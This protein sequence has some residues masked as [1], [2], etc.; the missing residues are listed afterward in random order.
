MLASLLPGL[1]TIRAPLAA[2]YVLL[3]AALLAFAPVYPSRSQATGVVADLYSLYDAAGKGPA[4][5][6]I[7]F[8][9]YLVGVVSVEVTWFAFAA[10]NGVAQLA[11]SLISIRY[12]NLLGGIGRWLF[13][14]TPSGSST[15]ARRSALETV[16]LRHLVQRYLRDAGFREEVLARVSRSQRLAAERGSHIPAPLRGRPTAEVAGDILERPQA[17]RHVIEWFVDLRQ[18]AEDLLWESRFAE[19]SAASVPGVL[20]ERDRRTAEADFRIGLALPT[21]ALVLVL[22]YRESVWFFLGG[23]VSVALLYMGAA[24]YADADEAVLRAVAQGRVTWPAAEYLST[25]RIH[26]RSVD[27]T[28]QL[29]RATPYGRRRRPV[30]DDADVAATVTSADPSGLPWASTSGEPPSP[31]RTSSTDPA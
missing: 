17:R 16:V 14:L 10:A 26:Y 23:L 2:G 18:H 11:Y 8:A 24:M 5:A 22:T 15:K 7:T 28:V 19:G 29:W 12:R 3:L 27:E 31:P 20:E 1:R 6:A 4:F 13:A 9:A 21:F 25:G 30:T